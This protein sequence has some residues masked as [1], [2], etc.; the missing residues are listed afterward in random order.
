[1]SSAV[2]LLSGRFV[3]AT[4]EEENT[5]T[6]TYEVSSCSD[7]PALVKADK[8]FGVTFRIRHRNYR[9]KLRQFLK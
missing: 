2:G 7:N 8:R 5:L 3:F 9:R 1:M 4:P 6:S